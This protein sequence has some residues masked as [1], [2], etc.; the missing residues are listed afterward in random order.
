VGQLL[1]LN[2]KD[3]LKEMSS[4]LQCGYQKKRKLHKQPNQGNTKSEE[5]QPRF[6]GP[7]ITALTKQCRV[8]HGEPTSS[9]STIIPDTFSTL[10]SSDDVKPPSNNAG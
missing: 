2:V 9:G 10:V 3:I 5:L 1:S 6:K 4:Q 7:K 8:A